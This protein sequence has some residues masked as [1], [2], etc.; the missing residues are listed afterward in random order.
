MRAVATRDRNGTQS[1]DSVSLAIIEQLQED[2]RRPYAA[3]GKAVGLSEAAV[4]QR[5]QKLLDQ[6][7][8][9]IVAVTDPLTV[10]FRRQA[11][12]GINVEGDLDPVADAL[13]AME[14]VEYVVMTA[15]SFDLLIEIVCEDDDHLLEMINK[16]IR[17]L[18]GVRTT[19]S[20]VYLK[21]RK[22][23]YTWGTR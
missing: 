10:G 15:G 1:I 23:T 8:M 9:Q 12:V 4:R 5:V 6:G 19:E 11:M 14:E 7:V 18:P 22:Q 17:T 13:T 20:F 3:I 2:G 21:L 16:R